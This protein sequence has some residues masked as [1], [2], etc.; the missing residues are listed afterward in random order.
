M[1]GLCA[2]SCSWQGSVLPHA[3]PP[4]TQQLPQ[5][6]SAE[7]SG[8]QRHRY[9]PSA[10]AAGTS[11]EHRTISAASMAAAREGRAGSAPAG[12]GAQGRTGRAAGNVC[13]TARE[14]PW[15]EPPLPPA[16]MGRMRNT[17]QTQPQPQV[18][19]LCPGHPRALRLMGGKGCAGKGCSRQ[20]DR[21]FVRTCAAF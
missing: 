9:P 10:M 13:P 17:R 7:F 3:T 16:E 1:A 19:Q 8:T 20:A 4:L 14:K 12:D 15:A 5:Q 6:V 18:P 21:H 2:A 11:R